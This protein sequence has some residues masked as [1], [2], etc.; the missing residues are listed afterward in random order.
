[1][2]ENYYEILGVPEGADKKDIKRAYF[3]LVRVYSPEKDIEKFQQIRNAYE[4]L[5]SDNQVSAEVPADIPDVP[6]AKSMMRQIEM[7]M[8]SHDY[9]SA[10]ETAGEAVRYFGDNE[11]FLY[12]QGLC[13]RHAGK[14]G[15][16]V[17]IFE[18]LIKMFPDKML[19]SSE[20]AIAYWERGFGKKAL[21]AFEKAYEMGCRD[22]DFLCMFSLCCNDR[23]EQTRGTEI[24]FEI[25]RKENRNLR[26][27]MDEML[28][29]FSGLL[30]MN[31]Y[32]E[33][34]VIKEILME[35][36]RFLV[37]ASAYLK[38]YEEAVLEIAMVIFV[39]C[40]QQGGSLQAEAEKMVDNLKPR[41]SDKLINELTETVMGSAMRS[42]LEE[43]ERLSELMKRGYE[44]FIDTPEE[45]MDVPQVLHF[46]HLDMKLCM[47]EEWPSIQPEI[48]IIK[49]EYPIYYDA[50]KDFI[51]Q[52]EQGEN[53]D[54]LRERL[55]KDYNRLES[56]V[57]GGFYYEEHP[58]RRVGLGEV[59]WDSEDGGT[60][61]RQG[62]KVGRNDPCP[63][64]SGK[65]YK[66]CCGRRA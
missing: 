21:A 29:A 44:A 52:L 57:G 31:I 9:Q 51:H 12:Y 1:M 46:M 6:L 5:M 8:K 25:L 42:K 24:L 7:Q 16:S 40:C 18:K 49:Q 20:A 26:D 23:D 11:T 36:Q 13:C 55:L 33:E 15:T 27:S 45:Y 60:Y 17:K 35:F 62:K 64:G 47:L 53:R 30:A 61:V 37:N 38:N 41:I 43:D 65:K 19:Y 10:A 34:T 66:N 58:E 32:A 54:I 3:K 56:Y 50:I 59:K 39:L 4:N 48:E 28:E 63:C 2:T 22:D 14:T